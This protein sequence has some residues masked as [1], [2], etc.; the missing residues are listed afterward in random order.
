L[1]IPF[2][3][4]ILSK[5][6]DLCKLASQAQQKM[7][8]SLFLILAPFALSCETSDLKATWVRRMDIEGT[9]IAN[10]P[11]YDCDYIETY[12]ELKKNQSYV[13]STRYIGREDNIQFEFSGRFNWTHGGT[14]I[15]L[16]DYAGPSFYQVTQRGL[17]QLRRNLTR[18]RG[19]DSLRYFYYKT[20]GGVSSF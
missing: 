5:S 17:V 6:K 1:L 10:L 19:Q 16:L 7:R 2:P 11:C 3:D 18:Y 14:M 20:P 9:Y 15:H 8:L 13:V 4:S 12:L